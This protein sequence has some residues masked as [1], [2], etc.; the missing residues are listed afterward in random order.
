MACTHE[1]RVRFPPG[2]PN[3]VVVQ[4]LRIPGPQPGDAGS[5]PANLAKSCR[6]GKGRRPWRSHK[7][8]HAGSIPASATKSRFVQWK[9]GGPTNRTRGFDSLTGYQLNG[10]RRQTARREAVNLVL[11]GSTPVAH[12][13]PLRVVGQSAAHLPRAQ[14]RGGSSPPDPTTVAC[15]VVATATRPPVTRQDPGSNP[16]PT[17]SL[18]PSWQSGYAPAS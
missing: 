6:G 13:K 10:G 17:A 3:E 4:R 9:D 7:P 18:I 16:G 8:R 14:A 1:M 5:S 15:R 11:T 12:P 2:P